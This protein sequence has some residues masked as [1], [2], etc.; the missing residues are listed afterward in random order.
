MI[1]IFRKPSLAHITRKIYFPFRR[2]FYQK[3][4]KYLSTWTSSGWVKRT[5]II[6]LKRNL[7][8]VQCEQWRISGNLCCLRDY[9]EVSDFGGGGAFRVISQF[10]TWRSLMHATLENTDAVSVQI[11]GGVRKQLNWIVQVSCWMIRSKISQKNSN[12]WKLFLSLKSSSNLITLVIESPLKLWELRYSRNRSRRWTSRLKARKS[13]A[14]LSCRIS[15]FLRGLEIIFPFM[16][17]N[18]ISLC[19]TQTVLG[20]VT[21]IKYGLQW[22]V[23]FLPNKNLPT[24][25]RGKF[26]VTEFTTL[27]Q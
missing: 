21:Q 26:H 22:N 2:L 16:W 6:C 19:L 27:T 14:K 23:V 9:S 15:D 18:L 24:Q 20:I 8:N 1:N 25:Q 11:P 13:Q 4:L 7:I 10:F 17:T 3:L 5:W 12:Q